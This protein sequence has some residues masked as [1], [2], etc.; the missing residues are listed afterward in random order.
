M[1]VSGACARQKA[2]KMAAAAESD[3]TKS[4]AEVAAKPKTTCAVCGTP[5]TLNCVNCEVHYCK[6]ECQVADWRKGHKYTCAKLPD[7]LKLVKLHFPEPGQN[8]T[9][10]SALCV[11]G[12]TTES[13][14]EDALFEGFY[15]HPPE[16]RQGF[17]SYLQEIAGAEKVITVDCALFV[18]LVLAARGLLCNDDGPLVFGIGAWA[19]W[20]VSQ[21]AREDKTILPGIN[22]D[23]F[24]GYFAPK[25]PAHARV[26]QRTASGG[27]WLLGPNKNGLYLG[28]A[29]SGPMR[30]PLEGWHKT[31]VDGLQVE[32]GRTDPDTRQQI[33]ILLVDDLTFDDYEVYRKP[34]E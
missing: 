34:A 8:I 1:M 24:P 6:K 5:T 31:L 25:N 17:K 21:R 4:D 15:T 32:M 30:L 19:P 18:Q 23:Y 12:I 2:P 3:S 16:A 28:M 9:K 33:A 14:G 7:A 20:L 22:S 11:K 29:K 27:Q 26:V 13:G 10:V